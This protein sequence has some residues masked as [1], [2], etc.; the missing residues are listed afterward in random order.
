MKIVAR[1][2]MLVFHRMSKATVTNLRETASN[3]SA[4]NVF[5]RQ[6]FRP[7][8]LLDLPTDLRQRHFRMDSEINFISKLRMH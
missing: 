6:H 3:A 8:L 2:H 1:S 7:E 5:A 4:K